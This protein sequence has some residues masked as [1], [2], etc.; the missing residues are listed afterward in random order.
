MKDLKAAY[1]TIEADHFAPK[2][3][4][5]FITGDRRETLRYEKVTWN[6]GG[7]E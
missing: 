5:S 3:E 4:I 7:E 6:I 2:M 1:R